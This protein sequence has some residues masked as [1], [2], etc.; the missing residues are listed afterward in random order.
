MESYKELKKELDSGNLSV[1][2]S[3]SIK[4][5]LLEI[6]KNLIESYGDEVSNI[7]LVNGKYK[8]QLGLLSALSKEKASTI[9]ENKIDLIA[10][11]LGGAR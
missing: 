2:E 6:Q 1:N 10:E 9:T 7:D 11:K 3:R 8:E 4:E 5:Q